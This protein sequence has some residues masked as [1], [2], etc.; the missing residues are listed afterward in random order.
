MLVHR[1]PH[2]YLMKSFTTVIK[3]SII[4]LDDAIYQAQYMIDVLNKGK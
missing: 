4:A 3:Y 1:G 2:F